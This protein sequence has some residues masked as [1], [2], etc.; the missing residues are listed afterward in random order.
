MA[1][2]NVRVISP[3]ARFGGLQ[4]LIPQGGPGLRGPSLYQADDEGYCRS[5]TR[6]KSDDGMM[7]PVTRSG[8]GEPGKSSPNLSKQVT[9]VKPTVERASASRE[10]S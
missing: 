4:C 2:S 10:T 6:L 3:P 7:R 8:R 1:I 9:V 5:W